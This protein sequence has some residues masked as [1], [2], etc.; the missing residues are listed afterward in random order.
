MHM[1]SLILFLITPPA[2]L[3]LPFNNTVSHPNIMATYQTHPTMPY[4]RNILV[5]AATPIAKRLLRLCTGARALSLSLSSMAYIPAFQFKASSYKSCS[6]MSGL[7]P[8]PSTGTG[9]GSTYASAD[10]GLLGPPG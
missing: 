6:L 7:A 10:G 5:A 8:S 3:T 1:E 4:I 9:T 2:T